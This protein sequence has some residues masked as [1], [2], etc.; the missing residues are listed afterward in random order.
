MPSLPTLKLL[1]V[2]LEGKRQVTPKYTI[3]VDFGV[4]FCLLHFFSALYS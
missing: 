4:I 3:K 1:S 2:A